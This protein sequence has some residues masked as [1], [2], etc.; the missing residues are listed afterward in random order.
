[1]LSIFLSTKHLQ[2][3]KLYF[4]QK[5]SLELFRVYEKEREEGL[6]F[7]LF[8]TLKRSKVK[9]LLQKEKNK[10]GGSNVW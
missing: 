10:G 1:M 7:N 8:M 6:W 5:I 2:E 9:S 3:I 4:L